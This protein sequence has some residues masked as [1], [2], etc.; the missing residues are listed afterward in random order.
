MRF[1]H[2][3]TTSTLAGILGSGL[4]LGSAPASAA[5]L[6]TFSIS[7][8]QQN[9]CTG[10]LMPNCVLSAAAGFTEQ[11]VFDPLL[12]GAF[13]A[14]TATL[15]S[16]SAFYSYPGSGSG[17]PFSTALSGRL[18]GPIATNDSFTQLT[19][20]FDT[21]AGNG[22]AGALFTTE[23]TSDTT[24]ATAGL[25]TQQD[26]F[27]Q[28]NLLAALMAPAAYADLTS[29]SVLDFLSAL[30]G[31]LAGGF[32][33]RGAASIFDAGTLQFT[34]YAFTEY[35]GLAT[36][37]GVSAVPE[38]ASWPLVGLALALTC[39]LRRRHHRP[40]AATLAQGAH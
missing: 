13:D 19:N 36:L 40:A 37:I 28:Y 25:R 17:S 24:D 8:V 14:S 18:T 15:F 11:F 20:D 27:K 1:R 34:Q 2:N 30:V 7:G 21:S 22:L 9:E 12:L 3:Q 31:K 29:V 33:E 35:T 32:D 26:Y 4:L 5:L 6:L 39:G 10:L 23:Q 16:S 38:P